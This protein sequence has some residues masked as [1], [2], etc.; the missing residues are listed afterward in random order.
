M[1]ALRDMPI[2]RK[3]TLIVM[4]ATATALLLA[5][6]AFTANDLL[7]LRRA[8]L[9]DL[10]ILAEITSANSAPA[11]LFSDQVALEETLGF[12]HSRPNIEVAAVT[13][14]DGELLAHYVRPDLEIV[15]GEIDPH[16]DHF[17]IAHN[18]LGH[19][20]VIRPIEQNGER[21]G[22]VYLRADLVPD[23]V[24]RLLS[25]LGIAAVVLV[26]A[27][28]S[29]FAV[30]GVLQRTIT[31]PLLRLTGTA[32][33]ISR[34]KVFEL[35][36]EDAGQDEIGR[37]IK[38]FN[39]MLGEIQVR[40]DALRVHRD[41]LEDKVAQRTRELETLND[42]LR[43]A[44]DCAE[45]AAKEM[46]FQAHHDALTGLPNRLMMKDRLDRAIADAARDGARLAVLFLDLDKF[47]VI[48]DSLGHAVGDQMLVEMG[49]RL[50]QCVRNEDTVA[51]LG[52]DEFMILLPGIN[53]R[54][55]A[56]LVAQKVVESLM[57]PILCNGHELHMTTS[58]GI[59]LYPEDGA[60]RPHLM[61][62]A[63]ISMY[64]AK[65]KGRN[66]F[67]FWTPEMED[68]SHRRLSMETELRK[69]VER[70]ELELH[71]QPKL[72]F[73]T[74]EI[75]G[76]EALLRWQH[77]EMGMVSPAQFVPIAEETGL[78]MPLGE[79]LLSEACRQI[80]AWHRAGHTGITVAV[81]ISACQFHQGH[82]PDLVFDSLKR[83]GLTG[84]AL[85]L[86]ITESV[87]MQGFAQTRKALSAL[88]ASGIRVSI[89]DFGTGYSSLSYLQRFPVDTV[90]IDRSFVSNLPGDEGAISIT[91]A[92]IAMAHSLG[93]TVVAEGVETTDQ[94]EFLAARG[95][96]QAQ[97]YLYGR[98]MPPWE[99]QAMLDCNAPLE[100]I[101]A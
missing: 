15:P 25:Y 4:A 23:M 90:K 45:H 63:D 39:A 57:T 40:D 33:R 34:E 14:S 1:R 97:G 75:T 5:A 56:G 78:I 52:G 82:M 91:T 38:S 8:V 17:G 3:L 12:L 44:R 18:F 99:L 96:D 98:P 35:R 62:N 66:N 10:Q 89:D 94:A 74:G 6:S 28:L 42:R 81:N 68:S 95:C 31:N 27:L 11:V 58:I 54:E 93:L 69:A 85:E 7:T 67:Q 88:R 71:Y 20:D 36:A 53:V 16:H 47:K 64:R 60:D 24:D 21:L 100:D 32:E 43:H 2:R 65:E 59:T 19:L 13:A 61:R 37:L 49:R 48:N 55:D 73:A 101:R 92:I 22:E 86:E 9:H 70:C 76:V 84:E 87:F 29:A 50:R 79:W 26:L 77:A 83:Y 41:Q 80:G 51:R 30:G 72:D 46:K